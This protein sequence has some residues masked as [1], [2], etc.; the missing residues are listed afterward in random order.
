M[1]NR[2]CIFFALQRWDSDKSTRTSL[3]LSPLTPAPP[4]MEILKHA[5][6]DVLCVGS[7]L[8][9]GK[10][11]PVLMGIVQLPIDRRLAYLVLS[12]GAVIGALYSVYAS[13]AV[14]GMT[15]LGFG[16]RLVQLSFSLF[17]SLSFLL[18]MA[19]GI[20][21]DRGT[22]LSVVPAFCVVTQPLPQHQYTT[23]VSF[24]LACVVLSRCL[25]TSIGLPSDDTGHFLS[26]STTLRPITHRSIAEESATVW[27][28]VLRALQLFILAFY[29]S[30]QHAPTQEYFNVHHPHGTHHALVAHQ[31]RARR[32]VYASHHHSERTR[33]A[34]LLGLVTAWVRVTFWYILCF[35]H[36]NVVHLMLGNDFSRGGFDWTCAILYMTTLLYSGSWTATQIWEQVLPHFKL[37]SRHE[38]LKF[39][40]LILGLA[41]LFRQ[42]EGSAV[43]WATNALTLL[44]LAT[45][46]LTLK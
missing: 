23:L 42:R 8:V 33:Y 38:R 15:T 13:R 21:Y 17:L 14:A 27:E 34:T 29:A 10:S 20:H 3:I 30:V 45:T 37:N 32:P 19:R 44:A 11:I 6:W 28:T 12:L 24:L 2:V 40:A 16:N 41:T 9:T 46:A 5:P 39:L 35:L 31:R 7:E 4:S 26:A 1:A 18:S 36:D 22:A 25:S 43:F